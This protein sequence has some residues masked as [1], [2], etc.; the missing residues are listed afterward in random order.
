VPSKFMLQL[1]AG[2]VYRCQLAGVG[3]WGDP[4][5]RDPAL[6][7]EDVRQDKISIAFAAR[8]HGVVV[9]PHTLTVDGA[10]TT[11]RRARLAREGPA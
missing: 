8:E 4:Y 11:A 6:V 2:D 3:G 7:E 9:N 10:A 1:N 5:E